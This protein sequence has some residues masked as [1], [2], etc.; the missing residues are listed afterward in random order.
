MVE[1]RGV[2]PRIFGC[3]PNVFPL[4]LHPHNLEGRVV[5]EPTMT[6]ATILRRTVWLPTQNFGASDGSLTHSALITSE[7]YLRGHWQNLEHRVGFEP[8]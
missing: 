7:R 6:G 3:R 8:T 5:V 4:A 2:E 1:M